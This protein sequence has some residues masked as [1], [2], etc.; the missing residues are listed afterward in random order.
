MN[1]MINAAFAL[2]EE[3][4]RQDIEKTCIYI[5]CENKP[6]FY[7]CTKEV[8]QVDSGIFMRIDEIT[9]EDLKH[10]LSYTD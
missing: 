7:P 3:M 4:E 8:I 2:I 9:L 5:F 1:N 6:I 10:A